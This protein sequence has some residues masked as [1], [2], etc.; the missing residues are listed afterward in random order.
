[1][2]ELRWAPYVAWKHGWQERG[3]LVCLATKDTKKHKDRLWCVFLCFL[4]FLVATL[5]RQTI[6]KEIQQR[7]LQDIC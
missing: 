2:A 1:M 7:K 4:V 3:S 6:L 5:K